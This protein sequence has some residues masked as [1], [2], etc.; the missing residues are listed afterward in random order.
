MAYDLEEQEQI[1]TLKSWWKQYGNLVTWLLIAALG[2]Y[3]AWS[4]WNYYQR[5][6]AAQAGQLYDEIT[7]AVAAKDTARVLRGAADMREKFGRTAYA[8]MAALTA[9][10]AAFDAN[11]LNGAKAQL[12][13]VVDSGRDEE[14]RALA[15]IRLAGVLLDEKAYDEGLK[16]LSADVPVAFAGALADRRGDLLMAQNKVAEARAAYQEALQKSDAK[17]PGRQLI[18]LKLDAIGGAKAAA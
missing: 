7:R 4:G 2:A 5:S 16:L 11:D 15:R 3:A 13:W 17:S 9:A 10:K 18:Q 8:E 6:Q 12:Q 1:E 14:Y